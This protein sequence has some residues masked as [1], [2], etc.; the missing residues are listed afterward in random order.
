MGKERRVSGGGY[1]LGC[2][3]SPSSLL[4]SWG[5][6]LPTCQVADRAG[7]TLGPSS[8]TASRTRDTLERSGWPLRVRCSQDRPHPNPT[9]ITVSSLPSSAP[10]SGMRCP[11]EV[12][13]QDIVGRAR[14][15]LFPSC[16]RTGL[17]APSFQPLKTS[18]LSSSSTLAHR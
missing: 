5:C 12:I 4:P 17:T 8:V 14:A 6:A 7:P 10:K 11:E 15:I 2:L 1:T 18:L 16:R 3:S 9:T 13:L